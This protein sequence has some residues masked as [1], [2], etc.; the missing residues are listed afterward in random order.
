MAG[1]ALM[2]MMTPAAP[3][4]MQIPFWL[5]LVTLTGTTPLLDTTGWHGLMSVNEGLL[6]QAVMGR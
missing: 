2:M 4:D 6:H 1:S 5:N 3:L